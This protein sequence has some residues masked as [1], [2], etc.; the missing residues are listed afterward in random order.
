MRSFTATDEGTWMGAEPWETGQ[1]PLVGETKEG[2]TIVAS[3]G[4]VGVYNPEGDWMAAAYPETYGEAMRACAMLEAGA[5]WK[6]LEAFGFVWEG[7]W[8]APS[9]PPE[10]L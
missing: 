3:A 4:M 1:E 6:D 9:E 5:P 8:S 7:E 10:V 2:N